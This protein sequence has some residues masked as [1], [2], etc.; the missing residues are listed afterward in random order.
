MKKG[1]VIL[2]IIG[3][4]ILGFISYVYAGGD[5]ESKEAEKVAEKSAK[6]A[7]KTAEKSAK[8][9]EKVSKAEAKES[10]K[11][12]KEAAKESTKSD[13]KISKTRETY[14]FLGKN[15]ERIEV[16]VKIE[17]KIR[18]GET[19]QKI[20]IGKVEVVSDVELDKDINKKIRAKLS[21]GENKEIKIMPNTASKIALSKLRSKNKTLEL[22]EVGEGNNLSVVYLS[23]A[24]KTT[25]F[26]GLFKIRYQLRAM[27]D[28]ETGEII[29]FDGKP[30]WSVLTGEDLDEK[31]MYDNVELVSI[32]PRYY[33]P[34]EV[35]LL[36]GDNF[37]AKTELGW[38]PTTTFKELA[39]KMMK[40][41]LNNLN[42]I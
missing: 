9:A 21:N 33:R 15:Q 32:N 12:E 25:K 19:Y 30:W 38:E 4:L 36:I 18:N 10:E 5:K 17:T 23:E 37:K 31:L 41:D 29:E 39:R 11:R 6:D 1:V 22:K 3:I 28:S 13:E 40:N 24:N 8:E 16:D 27:I 2:F 7:A 14:T 26:L 35:D 34:T 42:N 20:K